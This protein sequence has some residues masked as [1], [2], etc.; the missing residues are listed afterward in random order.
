MTRIDL[1]NGAGTELRMND[2]TADS[3]GNIWGVRTVNGWGAVDPRVMTMKRMATDG[4]V[5]TNATTASRLIQ[6]SGVVRV[7]SASNEFEA[8][9]MF[10]SACDS[11][12]ADGKVRIYEPAGTRH[13]L[14]RLSGRPEISLVPGPNNSLNWS[15]QFVCPNPALQSGA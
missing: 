3:D 1:V 15:V 4:L 13:A 5:V 10:E 9:I 14:V 2:E 12:S 7:A 11:I 6:L 8:L